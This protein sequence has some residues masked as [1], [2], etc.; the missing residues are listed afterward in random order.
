MEEKLSSNE[1]DN[2]FIDVTYK[3]IPKIKNNNYKLL[4]ITGVHNTNKNS[5]ICALVLIKYEDYLSFKKI[6]AYLNNMFNFNPKI[7]HINYSNALT[8]ALNEQHLFEKDPIIVHF[9]FHY[10]QSILKKMK[11]LKLYKTKLNKRS[12]EIIRNIELICF[13]P[14]KY[15][16]TYIQFLKRNLIKE[17]ETELPYFL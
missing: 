4:T 15:I 11:A 6:F 3:V 8:K 13:L 7:V 16:K 14:Y 9:F 10:V 5:Y 12:F 1:V 2:F 17:S